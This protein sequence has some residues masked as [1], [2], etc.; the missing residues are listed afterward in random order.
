MARTIRRTVEGWTH[1]CGRWPCRA[2]PVRISSSS[3]RRPD[4]SRPLSS[5][6]DLLMSCH[7]RVSQ[8]GRDSAIIK[9]HRIGAGQRS[10][11]N[12]IILSYSALS[13]QTCAIT[14]FIKFRYW[15]D[16]LWSSSNNRCILLHAPSRGGAPS[17][18][19]PLSLCPSILFRPRSPE[20]K[21]HRNFKFGEN[22]LPGA[23]NG[24]AHF[25]TERSDFKVKVEFPNRRTLFRFHCTRRL[26]A[27]DAVAVRAAK[28]T[29]Q[30]CY[31]SRRH[32][33]LM[34]QS[35]SR[36]GASM[37]DVHP[38]GGLYIVATIPPQTFLFPVV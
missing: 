8:V 32:P 27:Q 24:H 33:M 2:V 19:T 25:R 5:N 31:I 37:N 29:A 4:A 12:L 3:W 28:A 17:C 18:P 15:V 9:R 11:T 16:P 23:C 7:A 20:G 30:C 1:G 36:T 26:R 21:G 35:H 34:L 38:H 10:Q 22:I 13:M 6:D 14:T